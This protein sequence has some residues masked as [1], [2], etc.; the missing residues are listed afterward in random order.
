[1]AGQEPPPPAGDETRPTEPLRPAAPRQPVP[2]RQ[3]A[4]GEG[5][6]PEQPPD[7]P[8]TTSPWAA[9]SAGLVGLILGA[10]VGY[11]IGHNN[12][13]TKTVAS[14]PAVTRT[15][16]STKTVP[17]V[18]TVTSKTVT[19]AP[20]N[21]ATEQKLAQAEE[22]IKTLEKENEELSKKAEGQ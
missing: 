19:Q 4:A 9:V 10:L 21:P 3:P 2:P 11:L 15:V 6:S 8:R 5:Y 1:M 22:E 12:A 20:P 13:P 17:K 7:E 14:G 18:T 16:T